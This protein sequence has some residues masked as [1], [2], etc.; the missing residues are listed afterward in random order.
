MAGD[1]RGRTAWET[2]DISIVGTA[3]KGRGRWGSA[4]I[5]QRTF[6]PATGQSEAETSRIEVPKV[7]WIAK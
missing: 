1:E 3:L 7:R 4:R 5:S 6:D 2:E